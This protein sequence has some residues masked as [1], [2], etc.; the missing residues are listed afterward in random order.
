M[1]PV[2]RYLRCIHMKPIPV[3]CLGSKIC[4]YWL[5]YGLVMFLPDSKFEAPT[6][7]FDNVGR[8]I[9]CIKIIIS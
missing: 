4:S 2:I 9:I 7:F 1:T 3:D 5:K 8:G 6:F